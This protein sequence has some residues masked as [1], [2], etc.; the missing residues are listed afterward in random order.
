MISPIQT[1]VTGHEDPIDL[2]E[3]TGALAEF[4]RAFNGRDLALA[5]CTTTAR[6]RTPTCLHVTR[7]RC[8]DGSKVN[9]SRTGFSDSRR[10]IPRPC[11]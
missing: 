8:A 3:S 7:R 10:S 11:R 5:R 1:P 9:P 4:Y 2:R 6:S